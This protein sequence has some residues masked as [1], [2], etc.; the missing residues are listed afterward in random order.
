MINNYLY[1]IPKFTTADEGGGGRGIN[2]TSTNA[3]YLDSL[4]V[5]D[6]YA[7]FDPDVF[8]RTSLMDDPLAVC[9]NVS[10]LLPL[11]TIFIKFDFKY[12]PSP[13]PPTHPRCKLLA[14]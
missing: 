9:V 7:Q 2:R 4:C 3:K 10:T 5:I 12:S 11:N 8:G 1:Y 13:L 14:L 6:V